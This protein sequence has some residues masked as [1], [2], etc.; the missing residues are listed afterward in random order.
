MMTKKTVYTCGFLFSPKRSSVLLVC[1]NRPIWQS[2][3]WNGIGGKL[4]D[5]E[6]LLECMRR[7]FREETRIHVNSTE[8]NRF[9]VE[10]GSDYVVHFFKSFV[11]DRETVIAPD[12]NDVG[13]PL[14]WMSV[15]TYNAVGNL[16]W[17][18]PLALDWRVMDVVVVNAKSDIS[19]RPTW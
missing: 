18:I 15:P 10:E 4:S 1:K 9:A 2:G 6:T 16:H 8:W 13:E 12:H 11:S 7:E 17:L 14:A 19:E 3:L 5:G